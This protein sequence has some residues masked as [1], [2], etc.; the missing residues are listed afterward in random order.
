MLPPG[1]RGV[2]RHVRITATS[3]LAKADMKRWYINVPDQDLS[4]FPEG[5]EH[6]DDYVEAVEWAQ[7]RLR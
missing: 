5:T 1:N 6:F 3:R 7:T 4:Y 2:R